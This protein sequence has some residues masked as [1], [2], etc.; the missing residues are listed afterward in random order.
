MSV[1]QWR[2]E[3]ACKDEDP[4][5]FFPTGSGQSYVWQLYEAKRVCLSCPVSSTCLDVAL[6]GN[7][8]DGIWGGLDPNERLEL[9]RRRSG[10]GPRRTA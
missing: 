8:D 2:A 6:K 1:D 4:E 3:A 10:Q 5:L 9:R 7:C